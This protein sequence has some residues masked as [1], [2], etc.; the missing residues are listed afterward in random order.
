MKKIIIL[1]ISIWLLLI[2][3]SLIWNFLNIKN[4]KERVAFLT[5]RTIYRQINVVRDWN[6]LHKG[7]YVPVTPD[8]RPDPYLNDPYRDLEI[9]ETI[10][11]TKI[12]PYF[13]TR[14]L[15]QIAENKD[16]ILFRITSL[17]PIRP[18][19]RPSEK[20]KKALL[21]LR[22][23]AIEVG[24]FF[25]NRSRLSFFY[26]APLKA[27]KSCLK[28]H[29][30]Q[31][32]KVGEVMGGISV[33]LKNA[34]RVSILPMI[35]GHLVMGT[36]GLALILFLGIKI[37]AAYQTIQNQSVM[38]SLT[39]IPNRRY[40]SDRIDIEFKRCQRENQA[41]SIIL[42]DIDHFKKYNDHYG[43]QAGDQCLKK[44]AKTIK[45]TLHRSS[46]FCA[47]YGGEEF[48]VVLPN[49]PHEGALVVAE[50]IRIKI[51]SLRVPHLGSP[52]KRHLTISLGVATET[53][54]NKSW[55]DLISRAD[56][57]LYQSKAKGRNRVE[58]HPA[59]V[60]PDPMEM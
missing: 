23:N 41:I 54:H 56:R 2:C 12:N 15:S 46:D 8:T 34:P 19:N 59:P 39:G 53:I 26:M 20:E 28:C 17:T 14:Q 47:R 43:H 44:V 18:Q 51:E 21:K 36:T 7:V 30:R 48:I 57:A 4:E 38:D 5:A 24:E 27:Q 37:N 29:E 13:M 45:N 50:N 22:E 1:I 25:E 42:G 10:K 60:N 6:M 31:N 52:S 58:F 40:F 35:L 11:L 33:T 3:I 16:D 9:N 32:H 49:I 55:E